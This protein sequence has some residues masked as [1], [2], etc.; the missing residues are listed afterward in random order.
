MVFDGCNIGEFYGIPQFHYL[1][2]FIT[3][4]I[5]IERDKNNWQFKKDTISIWA[6]YN[7]LTIISD[8]WFVMFKSRKNWERKVRCQCECGNIKDLSYNRVKHSKTKSCWCL[9]KKLASDRLKWNTIWSWR[10]HSDES[11]I[12]MRRPLNPMIELKDSIRD[13][14]SYK[15]WR[16][17][18]FERDNYTCQIS[19]EKSSWNIEAHHLEWL[20]SLIVKYNINTLYDAID[21]N[22]LWNIDNWVTLNNKI[23]NKFHCIYWFWNNTPEQF[24]EFLSSREEQAISL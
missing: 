16:K 5:M 12:K 6:K 7:M 4:I 23:H 22:E 11:K 1:F 8:L 9:A 3:V 24:K 13:S 15:N 14:N 10:K 17:Q 19:W 21:C 18:V 20:T 2:L